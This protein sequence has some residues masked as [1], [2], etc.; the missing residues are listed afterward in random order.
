[1]MEPKFSGINI[2]TK[3]HALMKN[4]PYMQKDVDS[5]ELR[6]KYL[7]S[8]AVMD[9]IQPSLIDL[10]L[11][12]LPEFETISDANY[13]TQKGAIWNRIR[14]KLTLQVVDIVSGEYCTV[15][16]EGGGTDSGDKA[17]AK[18]QTQASKNLWC[19]LLNVSIGNDPE[20]DP[21]T[22]K[23]QFTPVQNYGFPA[24]ELEIV[25][26]WNR[27]GWDPQGIP[28]YIQARFGRPPAQ[29]TFEECYALMMEFSSYAQDKIGGQQ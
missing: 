22:D 28:Q 2:A 24:H 12:A 9:K 23:Q 26:T 16:G 20:A 13:T 17:V 27:A 15:S 14:V 10:G 19:K 1:M 4:N 21:N 18:A 11:I 8:E 5:K 3:I 29:L 7:S 25:T 6:Y